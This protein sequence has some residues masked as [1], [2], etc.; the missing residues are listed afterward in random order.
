MAATFHI[1]YE[2]GTKRGRSG[3]SPHVQRTIRG[4]TAGGGAAAERVRNGST[5]AD[6]QETLSQGGFQLRRELPALRRYVKDVE[7]LVGFSVDEDDLDVAAGR[8]DRSGEI[9]KKTG[10]V[11]GDHLDQRLQR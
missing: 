3:D 8:G 2:A 10:T 4:P 1:L 6:G 9:V 5:L 11:F 7:S